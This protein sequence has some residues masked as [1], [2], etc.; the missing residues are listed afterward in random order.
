MLGPS[1]HCFAEVRIPLQGIE[2]EK[3][4]EKPD[5]INNVFDVFR[6]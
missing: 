3:M 4:D 1:L 2:I 6:I 5:N